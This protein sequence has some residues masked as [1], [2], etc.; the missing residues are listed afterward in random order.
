MKSWADIKAIV[1]KGGHL[2]SVERCF[3][4]VKIKPVITDT[5]TTL[6]LSFHN[7]TVMIKYI[8]S[9]G[10]DINNIDKNSWTPLH[11]AVRNNRELTVI[12][13]LIES[14]ADIKAVTK[15]G[16]NLLHFVAFNNELSVVK[17][18]LNLGLDINTT[19]EN[20]WTP[21][22]YAVRYNKNTEIVKYFLESGADIEVKTHKG[23]SLLRLAMAN[24]PIVF[25]YLHSLGFS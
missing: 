12:K 14:G 13:Y 10:F 9:L 23:E 16:K 5:A 7:S 3:N 17:Y 22:Q 2:F 8:V 25:R 4:C 1:P 11:Y 6:Y 20:G 24:N 19:D 18:V 21:L 15:D